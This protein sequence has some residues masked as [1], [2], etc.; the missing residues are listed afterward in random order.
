MSSALSSSEPAKPS[1][2]SSSEQY[3]TSDVRGWRA[4]NEAGESAEHASSFKPPAAASEHSIRSHESSTT[5]DA[6]SSWDRAQS[7]AS[8]GSAPL[9]RPP[10]QQ[11]QEQYPNAQSQLAKQSVSVE[12]M[13]KSSNPWKPR[14]NADSHEEH[15]IRSVKGCLNK[16][17][18]DN[19]D[20]LVQKLSEAGIDTPELLQKTIS[21]LFDK[22]VLEP[23]FCSLY[24][25]CCVALS[26]TLPQFSPREG[27]DKPVTFRRILLN[28]CQ[29]EFE[30]ANQAHHNFEPTEGEVDP[31]YT[32]RKV[33]LRMLGNIKLIGELYKKGL[34]QERILHLCLS[35]LLGEESSSSPPSEI[36]VEGMCVLLETCGKNLD[37]HSERKEMLE[38]YMDRLS[39]LSQDKSFSSRIR[40]RC[41]DVIDLRQNEWQP[42]KEKLEAKKIIEVHNEAREAGIAPVGAAEQAA[43]SEA[44][45]FPAQPSALS[46]KNQASAIPKRKVD[47]GDG[48]YTA[49]G[50]GYEPPAA[51]I[52]MPTQDERLRQQQ[53]AAL[54]SLTGQVDTSASGT[55]AASASRTD[56]Q[57]DQK[58]EANESDEINVRAYV[59]EM[60]QKERSLTWEEVDERLNKAL[61]EYASA[62]DSAEAVECVREVEQKP[63]GGEVEPVHTRFIDLMLSMCIDRSSTQMATSCASLVSKCSK[64]LEFEVSSITNGI[65]RHA[66]EIE[67]ISIDVPY[68]TDV[69]ASLVG[70]LMDMNLKVL[71]LK[72]IEELARP[73]QDADTRRK[74][75]AKTLRYLKENGRL[76]LPLPKLLQDAEVDILQLLE[77]EE[78]DEDLKMFLGRNKLRDVWDFVH[79]DLM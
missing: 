78:S 18:P 36:N 52:R 53:E 22:A 44:H 16:I 63:P 9:S 75:V 72:F 48:Q 60:K 1:M 3:I 35:E 61:E 8:S 38:S 64:E 31:E 4:R 13:A 39:R 73:I 32:R 2:P 14:S 67:E 47:V 27:D 46:S 24:A 54:R 42:R 62:Q 37:E 34:L 45:L 19:F 30:G 23:T 57:A 79:G 55:A 21:E 58:G 74:L 59:E 76:T 33:K 26:Q 65:R 25:Q 41:K 7:S 10:Q 71:S 12:Q 11:Q 15:V 77:G 51:D 43:A 70:P 66:D 6:S 28:T 50:G 29:D 5:R 20:Q 68:A 17:S 69:I 56:E 49:L 40:F